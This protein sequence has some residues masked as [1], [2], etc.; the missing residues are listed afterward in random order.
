MSARTAIKAYAD[1]SVSLTSHTQD[2]IEE[3]V[4]VCPQQGGYV[5]DWIAGATYQSCKQLRS[6]GPTLTCPSRD[7][8]LG[9]IRSEW[10]ARQRAAR[11]AVVQS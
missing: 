4:F 1:G 10:R 2:G 3:R 5:R 8:L 6:V 9:L 11:I 7:A